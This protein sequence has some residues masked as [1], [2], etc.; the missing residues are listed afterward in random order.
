MTVSPHS[1]YDVILITSCTCTWSY[2]SNP[3]M[4]VDIRAH[5]EGVLVE[6]NMLASA[7]CLHCHSTVVAPYN[8]VWATS[9]KH[10]FK[11]KENFYGY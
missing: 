1:I 5:D 6:H 4:N 11:Y 9:N 7:D 2:F 10:I 8:N 3:K